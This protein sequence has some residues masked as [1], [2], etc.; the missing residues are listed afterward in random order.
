[1]SRSRGCESRRRGVASDPRESSR[2]ERSQNAAARRARRPRSRCSAITAGGYLATGEE[3]RRQKPADLR[4]G[5]LAML[6]RT[7]VRS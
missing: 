4:V 2:P 6:P 3:A 5:T 1:M 7:T